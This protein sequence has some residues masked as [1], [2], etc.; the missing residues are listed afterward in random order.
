MKKILYILFCLVPLLT[1]QSCT[2]RLEENLT[3]ER[4]LSTTISVIVPQLPNAHSQTRAMDIQPDV[5]SLHVAV[6]DENGYLL[7]Y[8]EATYKDEKDN[9]KTGLAEENNK[10][11]DYTVDLTP[12]DFKTTLHF[13]GNGPKSIRFG[14]ETEVM[15][16]LYT[17][18][19]QEAYWQRVVLDNGIKFEKNSNNQYVL[20]TNVANAL[21]GIELIRNFAWINL[22]ESADNFSIISYC[23]VNTYDKGSIAPYNSAKFGFATFGNDQSYNE[24][25]KGQYTE[26]A[27]NYTG[28]SYNGFIP[29]EATLNKKIPDEDD[30]F[31]ADAT[32]A[33]NNAYFIYEREKGTSDPPF[34]LVKGKYGNN[35]PSYYKVDLRDDDGSFPIIRNFRYTINLE[36]VE[37]AGHKSAIEAANSSGSGDVSTSWDTEKFTNISDNEARIFV[38]DTE[39]TVTEQTNDLEVLFKFL[40]YDTSGIGITSNGSV[41]ATEDT[42]GDNVIK[43]SNIVG[44]QGDEWYKVKI[45]TFAPVEGFPKSQDIIIKGTYTNAK[46]EEKSLQRKVTINLRT[47]YNMQLIC[48]PAEITREMGTPFDVLIKLPNPANMN[49]SVFPLEFQ[50]EAENQSMTPNLGDDLP[51]ITGKSIVTGKEGK[52]TIGFIKQLEYSDYTELATDANGYKILP[53]HFKSNKNIDEAV[54]VTEIYSQNKYFNLAKTNLG[55]YAPGTF[56]GELSPMNPMLVA[57]S[58]VE[59][60][61]TMSS[62]LDQ[63]NVRLVLENLTVV[64][65]E[66]PRLTRIGVIDGKVC[67]EIS[68][69]PDPSLDDTPLKLRVIESGK[70]ISVELSANKFDNKLFEVDPEEGKFTT[71]NSKLVPDNKMLIAGSD[72]NFS[73]KMSHY[74]EKVTVELVNLEPASDETRLTP[75]SGQDGTYIFTPT[76]DEVNKDIP[77]KLKVKETFRDIRV[78]LSA[79]GFDTVTASKS[80]QRGYFDISALEPEVPVLPKGSIVKLQFTMSDMPSGNV[81]V[82]LDNLKPANDDLLGSDRTYSFTPTPDDIKN[83]VEFELEVVKPG[84]DVTV[85]L[86]ADDS[87]FDDA[88]ESFNPNFNIPSGKINVG[89]N[90]RNY[91]FTIYS[92][93]PGNTQKPSADI[94]LSDVFGVG[95]KNNNYVNT[96]AVALDEQKVIALLSSSAYDSIYVYVR[97][98]TNKRYY[99]AEVKLSDLLNNTNGSV[100]ISGS[101][102][103]K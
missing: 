63:G 64:S 67:Y 94:T 97:Y 103:Q 34:I 12:T 72:V 68:P 16:K 62:V 35:A 60:T 55:Y 95:N 31:L 17:E 77:L 37:H 65:D 25:V 52:T 50:L 24:I 83:G 98:V 102:K 69:T 75:V 61:Y 5:N 91:N 66:E 73:F 14:T 40:I 8:V 36:K 19:G 41:T 57:E 71:S 79:D 59:F 15:S 21:K 7:E 1:M 32:T 23:V 84:Q 54:E 51:A 39:I 42:K 6:F 99:V 27:T 78:S 82:T 80:P 11:Y 90:L 100:D 56:D 33:A 85:R 93:D 26:N 58:L 48:D 4:K 43:S 70:Q 96:D 10:I 30:W 86:S 3:N 47:K 18:K 22:I 87:Y 49:Q 81:T 9:I 38:S 101:F 92:Q 46:G 88:T 20:D 44:T 53:C 45:S 74:S 2:E 76:T 28:Q 13:I 29:A 89:R